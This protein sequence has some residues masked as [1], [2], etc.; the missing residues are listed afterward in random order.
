MKRLNLL[1]LEEFV[2]RRVAGFQERSSTS[3][4][5]YAIRASLLVSSILWGPN[6]VATI[7]S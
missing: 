4:I 3:P 6:M 7:R 5:T 2:W 1:T